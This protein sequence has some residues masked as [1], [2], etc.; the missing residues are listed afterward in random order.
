MKRNIRYATVFLLYMLGILTGM[1]L[2]SHGS[3]KELS[4]ASNIVYSLIH[5]PTN[6][7]NKV[8]FPDLE[9]K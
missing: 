5:G 1:L 2:G 7:D 9:K 3:T 8:F 4:N 6:D